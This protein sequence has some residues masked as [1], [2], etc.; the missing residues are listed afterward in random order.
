MH[1][2]F[3]DCDVQHGVARI[4]LLG[5][6]GAGAAEFCDE[7]LDLLLRLQEDRAA[8]VLLLSDDGGSLDMAF[9]RRGLAERWARGE[10]PDQAAGDLDVIRRI[11]TLMHELPKPVI[12]ALRGDVRDGGFGLAM[13]CDVRLASPGAVFTPP[14]MRQGLLADWGLSH[15]LPRR[16]GAGRCLEMIWS[17]RSLGGQEAYRIGLVDRLIAEE[18][19]D[20]EVEEF[21]EHVADL[22]QP[23]LQLSK[24]TVQQS[25]Q[26]DLTT[27]LSLE[28]ESQTQCWESRETAEAMA[29][30]QSGRRPEYW[31]A[32]EEDEE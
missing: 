11:T 4:S 22:P 8:R 19:W 12:A 15:L 31:A 1:Y 27:A 9:D 3:L 2:E 26:F 25:T 30:W 7:F 16:I 28:F 14:E 23:A 32:V 29:S 5:A 18:A 17:N 13:N 10:G 20:Q 21:A 6:G 24:M